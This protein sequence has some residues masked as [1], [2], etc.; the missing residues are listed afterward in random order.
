MRNADKRR[1][2]L[3]SCK[4]DLIARRLSLSIPSIDRTSTALLL[5]AAGGILK[6]L[7]ARQELPQLNFNAQVSNPTSVPPMSDGFSD[8]GGAMEVQDGSSNGGGNIKEWPQSLPMVEYSFNKSLVMD[9]LVSTTFHECGDG[10][11]TAAG[12][13]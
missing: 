12:N 1:L 13:R 5:S 4:S 8:L 7:K 2:H 6:L 9:G 3:A 10:F 11:A